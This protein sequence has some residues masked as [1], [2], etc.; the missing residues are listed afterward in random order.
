VPELRVP[1]GALLAASV[2]AAALLGGLAVVLVAS[3]G[4]GDSQGS[5]SGEPTPEIEAG[6]VVAPREVLF[7]DT[8][9]ARF[10]I[11]VDKNRVD[12]ESV[13]IAADLSPW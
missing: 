10:E 2:V 11:V 12:P 1:R 9:Q 8:V 5:P 3:H 13:R 4:D 6:V 7:G